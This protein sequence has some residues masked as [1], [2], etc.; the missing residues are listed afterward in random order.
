MVFFF[1]QRI[2]DEDPDEDDVRGESD[3]AEAA[4]PFTAGV[5]GGDHMGQLQ[6]SRRGLPEVSGPG[7]LRAVG[8]IARLHLS[9][10]AKSRSGDIYLQSRR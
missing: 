3:P 1:Q 2:W 10:A 4:V 9:D 5:L 8:K 6:R 7:H